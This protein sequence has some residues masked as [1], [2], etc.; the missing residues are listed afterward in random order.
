MATA[1]PMDNSTDATDIPVILRGSIV[2]GVVQTVCVVLV[3]IINKA[4]TGTADAALTGVVV[5]VGAVV[6]M[7]YPAMRTRP[8]TIEGIAGAAG[9]GL[10]AALVFLVL[11]VA[12]TRSAAA[13]TG[14]IIRRG[15]WSAATSPG[16]VH[17]S[18]PIRPTRMVH[19]R[20]RVPWRWSPC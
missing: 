2:L 6:T 11:D 8:R 20:C 13:P 9:I 10:G 18:S 15:G 5:A 3:S 4:M 12:L 17:G 14:G 19:P 16:S 7:F 1:V